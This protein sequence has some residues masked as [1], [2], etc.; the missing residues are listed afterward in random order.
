[1]H[2]PL[3][4]IFIELKSKKMYYLIVAFLT[5]SLLPLA[6]G[7]VIPIKM[8]EFSYVEISMYSLYG[9]SFILFEDFLQ[10]K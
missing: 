7:N 5:Q 9:F 8:K 4:Q 10:N 6:D 2:L 3:L 1:M